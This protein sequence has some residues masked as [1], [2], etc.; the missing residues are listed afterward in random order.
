MFENIRLRGSEKYRRCIHATGRCSSLAA[1]E[2]MAEALLN[3]IWRENGTII[4][5]R[6]CIVK[7]LLRGKISARATVFV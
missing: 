4:A 1:S 2:T 3:F 5:L 6:P 7:Y